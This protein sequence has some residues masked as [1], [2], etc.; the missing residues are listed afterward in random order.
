MFWRTH[1]G[2]PRTR[3]IR[4]VIICYCSVD[5]LQPEVSQGRL[6]CLL[7]FQTAIA[8]LT[9]MEVANASLLDEATAAAE[10]MTL[11]LRVCSDK[12][13]GIQ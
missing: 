3:R 12:S 13:R 11:A 7:N 9:G 5:I 8:D 6:E 1:S 2:I 10:A 4:H